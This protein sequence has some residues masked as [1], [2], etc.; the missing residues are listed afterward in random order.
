[1]T[2]GPRR[3]QQADTP[4]TA[5]GV[6]ATAGSNAAGRDL[7]NPVAIRAEYA[8]PAEAYAP[9]PDDA[10]RSGMSNIPRSVLF[11]GRTSELDA[12]EAAFTRA[13][14]VVVHAVHGLGGVGKSALAAHWAGSRGEPVRWWI[15][16]DDTAKVDA[17]LAG[18]ARALH[19]GLAGLPAELQTERAIEWL[20]GHDGWLLVLDNVEDPAHIDPL[21]NRV[22]GRGRVL[23]TTRRATG[24]H[25]HATTVRLGVLE[26]AD[27]LDLFVRIL[28]QQGPRDTNGADAVCAELGYLALAVEQA[29]AFCAE[30]G[31]TPS[32]Y[33]GMLAQWPAQMFAATS[34]GGDSARTIARIW[35]ITLDRLTDTPLAGD[36]LRLLAWY[37]PDHIPRDLLNGP[38]D[39]PS[40]AVALGRLAAYNM[41]TDNHDGTLSVHRL[42]Q[43]VARTP[44]PH[45]L[46]RHADDIARA[47]DHAAELLSHAYPD[48]SRNPANWPRYRALLPH[49]DALTAHHTPDHDTH[50][51]AD[52]LSEAAA[53]RAEQGA[54][55]SALHAHQRARMA[56]E[57]MLGP[58]HPDA[59][60]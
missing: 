29:A 40:R 57:R 34:A 31:T 52:A 19:P 24:W 50:H 12:L 27:A 51:T 16:A 26:P 25:R 1:M 48:D 58:D 39:P 30:T 13:G 32:D 56:Y 47:R 11:V 6:S 42:V 3:K 9:I 60:T 55:A 45:D 18:L 54:L 15:T 20:G 17:G 43:A 5:P 49:T 8:L 7:F 37:A 59:L 46:H 44:D 41:V 38:A 2:R 36:L 14:E 22:A 35:R 4:T 28:I 10:A 33:L 53:Y 21:L 23:V